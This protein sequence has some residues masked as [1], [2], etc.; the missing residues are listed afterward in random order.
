MLVL[1]AGVAMTHWDSNQHT[2]RCRYNEYN[3][4]VFDPIPWQDSNLKFPN[5]ESNAMTIWDRRRLPRLTYSSISLFV[6]FFLLFTFNI[7]PF[8][9]VFG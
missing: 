7:F 1:V 5:F 2:T 9:S 4:G 6:A 3:L 8:R